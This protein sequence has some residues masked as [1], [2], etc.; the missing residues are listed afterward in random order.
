ML[1]ALSV[2]AL[3][4]RRAKGHPMIES[5]AAK[6]TDFA[7]AANDVGDDAVR[8]AISAAIPQAKFPLAFKMKG[9]GLFH[10][11]DDGEYLICGPFRVLAQTRDRFS[12]S[13]GLLVEWKDDD[14]ELHRLSIPRPLLVGD[15]VTVREILANGGLSLSPSPKDRNALIQFLNGVRIDRRA[16][17]VS[18][19]GWSD[20]SF[21]LPD[22]DE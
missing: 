11:R 16:R 17:A 18:R 10:E 2:A 19:V 20:G 22:E 8:E 14:G 4:C 6:P 21:A 9:K 13:W 7:D 15:G 5:T 1:P 12:Q 3:R